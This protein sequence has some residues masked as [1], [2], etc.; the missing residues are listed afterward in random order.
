MR[1]PSCMVAGLGCGIKVDKGWSVCEETKKLHR[2]AQVLLLISSISNILDGICMM[3]NI[4]GRGLATIRSFVSLSIGPLVG[5]SIHWSVTHELESVKRAF[6]ILGV[7]VK[8]EGLYAPAHPSIL[9]VT[10]FLG[11]G[12]KGA[13]D[14]T[15]DDFLLSTSPLQVF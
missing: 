6:E 1:K 12:P 4:F 7:C 15:Q 10:C 11:S 13:D 9:C 14:F 3:E 2:R 5:G 8:V